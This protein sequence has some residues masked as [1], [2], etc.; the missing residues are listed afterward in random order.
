MSQFRVKYILRIALKICADER[1]AALHTFK[2]YHLKEGTICNL[3]RSVGS[4]F[5]LFDVQV[6]IMSQV[7]VFQRFP[8]LRVFNLKLEQ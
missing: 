5:V 8:N 1:V 2:S 3:T 4:S 7:T 6:Q